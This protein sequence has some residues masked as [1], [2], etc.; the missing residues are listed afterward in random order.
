MAAKYTGKGM[1]LVFNGV[2]FGSG[3]SCVTSVDISD[4]ADMFITECAG[5]TEKEHLAGLRA[6]QVD[7]QGYVNIDDEP[8]LNDI[9]PGTIATDFDFKP[10]GNTPTYTVFTASSAMVSSRSMP[11]SVGSVTTFSFSLML[12]SLTIAAI[13]APP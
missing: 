5:A 6:I 11:V 13:P 12:D 8:M 10:A 2:T 9:E 4:D 3:G 1:L 7:V